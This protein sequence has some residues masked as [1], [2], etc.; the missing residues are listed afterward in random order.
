MD[1]Y[2]VTG[3]RILNMEWSGHRISGRGSAH[4]IFITSRRVNR[5]RVNCVTRRHMQNRWYRWRKLPVECVR[6]E[7]MSPWVLCD[8]R[9]RPEQLEQRH[10][11]NR[12]EC[13][14]DHVSSGHITLTASRRRWFSV[15]PN[16]VS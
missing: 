5:R 14:R 12:S 16:E 4:A 10:Q 11:R 7:F 9:A 8:L 15:P 1:R 6:F 3:H 13:R 2:R